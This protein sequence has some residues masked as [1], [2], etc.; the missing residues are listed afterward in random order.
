MRKK[1]FNKNK[2]I[3]FWITGLSGSGK[4]QI[5]NKISK[6]ISK[7]YGPTIVVSGDELRNIFDLKKY[8]YR[9]RISNSRKF[10]K[11]AKFI[12]DKKINLIFAIVG[13][14]DQPRRWNR[15]YIKNYIEIYIKSD[16]KKIIRKKRKRIYR[17]TN[18][19]N[20][21]GIDIKPELP[22]NYD[23]LINNNFKKDLSTL[24]NILVKKILKM[25]IK[26]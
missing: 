20:I 4:T 8:D 26:I 7:L 2:G 23:I 12:T 25:N 15:K 18:K 14:M 10:C 21:V 17:S 11:F 1:Y 6:K 22:K 24:S 13:M 3:L 9:S 16:I 19:K 5:A